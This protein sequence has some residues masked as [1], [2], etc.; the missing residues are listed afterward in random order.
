MTQVLSFH[1]L[2]LDQDF[3]KA[4]M[5]EDKQTINK[6]LYSVGVDITKEYNVISRTHRPLSF[7]NKQPIVGPM[8]EYQT[9]TD[10]K[11][12]SSP[13]ATWEEKLEACEDVTLKDELGYLSQEYTQTQIMV[14]IAKKKAKE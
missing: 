1:D 13:Y 12:L 8:L 7:K 10:P 14:D 6:L 3:K 5:K 9:R 2:F 4:W 11:W